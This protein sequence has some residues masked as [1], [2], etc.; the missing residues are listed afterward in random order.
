MTK[1]TFRIGFKGLVAY[2]AVMGFLGIGSW[3][4]QNLPI[5]TLPFVFVAYVVAVIAA[6]SLL[7]AGE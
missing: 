2:F 4:A 6:I 1:K 5:W 7:A 3:C